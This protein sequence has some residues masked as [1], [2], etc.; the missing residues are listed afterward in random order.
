MRASWATTLFAVALVACGSDPE[1]TNGDGVAD[2]I[3]LPNN[4]TVVTPTNPRGYV[5][6]QILDGTTRE[7]LSGA[8]VTLFGG[9]LVGEQTTDAAGHF[10]FGPIASGARFSVEISSR[11]FTSATLGNLIIEDSAGDFP[12]DNGALY[13][14]PIALMPIGGS[15]T[16]QIVSD[17]GVPVQ[18]AALTVESA[19]AYFNGG[20]ARGSVVAKGT[21]GADGSATVMGLPNVWALP[22]RQENLAS[23][24]VTI[25]PVDS[26]GDMV[27]DLRGQ[28]IAISGA[29]VRAATQPRLVVLVKDGAR[30]ALQVVSSNIDLLVNANAAVSVLGSDEPLR[31]VF[32]QAIERDSLLVDVRDETGDNE[33][34]MNAV[35]GARG[36]TVELT[37]DVTF[38]EG[39]EYN[40]ALRAQSQHGETV[41][42]TAAF[43]ARANPMEPIRVTARYVD[44]NGDTLWGMGNDQLTITL[45][46]PVGRSGLNPAF[47]AR[48]YVELDL[49]GSM[50]IGDGAGE[51]P[52]LG[53]PYPPP[54]RINAQEPNPQNG[55]TASGFTR[56]LAPV[57]VASPTALTQFQG[58]MPFEIRID[59]ADHGGQFV[60]DAGG[61]A[62][63]LKVEGAATLV[64]MGG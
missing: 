10:Q 3:V 20:N 55:V 44:T 12:T 42:K 6:G 22:P 37:H 34:T 19:L 17:E 5:A 54:I 56:F 45:S 2:G 61:R 39:Q 46:V 49:D 13:V 11:G 47:N 58:P 16:V 59:P 63:P 57:V 33:L 28:T 40:L 36:N 62:A 53:A 43:F 26:N 29:D 8:K 35:I 15:L 64:P 52:G 21:S 50:T 25:A 14:G 27:P 24:V 7:P 18:G 9:G 60:T 48:L 1:D 31:I 23:M 38:I 4:V 30:Q 32:N 51:L 41:F